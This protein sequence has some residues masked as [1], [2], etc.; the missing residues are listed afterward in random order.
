MNVESDADRLAEAAARAD[1]ERENLSYDVSV[2]S[3]VVHD[4]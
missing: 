2:L 4:E 3:V 1:G